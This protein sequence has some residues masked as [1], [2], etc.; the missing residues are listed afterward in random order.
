MDHA[1]IAMSHSCEENA[2][3]RDIL[4]MLAMLDYLIAQTRPIDAIAARCLLMA[5]ESLVEAAAR[6]TDLH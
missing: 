5:R 2:S 6:R 1:V 4:A 3:R